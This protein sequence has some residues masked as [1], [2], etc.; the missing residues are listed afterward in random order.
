MEHHGITIS[1]KL[2]AKRPGEYTVYIFEDKTTSELICVTKLPNWQDSKEIEIGEEGFLTYVFI[3][4]MEDQ[5]K[6][7]DGNSNY[8]RYSANYFQSFLPEQHEVKNGETVVK[9]LLIK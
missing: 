9:T 5:W 8:Y 1:V 7:K 2:R 6:D 4:S 3:N